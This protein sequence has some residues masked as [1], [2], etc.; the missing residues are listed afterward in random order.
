MTGRKTFDVWY[1]E[2]GNAHVWLDDLRRTFASHAATG[3]VTLA[4]DRRRGY[5][6]VHSAPRYTLRDGEH[7]L[8]CGRADS[9]GYLMDAELRAGGGEGYSHP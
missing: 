3:K 6:S 8:D 2:V 4:V 5:V 1:L 7:V 9:W